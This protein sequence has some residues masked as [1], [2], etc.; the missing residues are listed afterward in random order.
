MIPG[1]EEVRVRANLPPMTP[2]DVLRADRS[3]TGVTTGEGP[4]ALMRPGLERRGVLTTSEVRGRGNGERVRVAGAVTHRQR[5]ATGG[6]IVF[7]SLEDETGLL[8]VTCLPEVWERWR[9]VALGS[10]GLCV[11]GR[12]EAQDGAVSVRAEAM[13][14]LELPVPT[15]SRDFR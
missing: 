7:L 2:L 13:W 6:G 1:L 4:L 5:P 3:R 12:V 8:N 9:G 15:R 11:E 14:R 10:E